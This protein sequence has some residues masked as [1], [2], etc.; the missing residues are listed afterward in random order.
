MTE[1]TKRP[2]LWLAS[3]YRLRTESVKTSQNWWKRLY[4]EICWLPM[5][6][7]RGEARSAMRRNGSQTCSSFSL[8]FTPSWETLGISSCPLFPC[9]LPQLSGRFLAGGAR[10][11]RYLKLRLWL[12]LRLPSGWTR[13]G[14][15]WISRWWRRIFAS[16]ARKNTEAST[17]GG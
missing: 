4:R 9:Y 13:A 16:E 15:M 10:P 1:N 6:I 7:A 14:S 3:T 17:C 5:I 2:S 11:T 12:V 8:R